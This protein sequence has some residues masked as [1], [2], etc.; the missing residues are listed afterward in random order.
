MRFKK[1]DKNSNNNQAIR[2]YNTPELDIDAI[3]TLKNKKVDSLILKVVQQDHRN[4]FRMVSASFCSDFLKNKGVHH[5]L[6]NM[7]KDSPSPTQ[8]NVSVPINGNSKIDSSTFIM[9]SIWQYKN[10][11]DEITG[12]SYNPLG[13][14]P[15]PEIKDGAVIVGRP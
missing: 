15:N 10:S 12:C 3:Y 4:K 7:I 13:I 6:I 14:N 2:V 9:T 5:L 11:N 8:P 1:I